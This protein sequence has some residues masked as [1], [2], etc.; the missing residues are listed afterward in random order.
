ML[1]WRRIRIAS[2]LVLALVTLTA[3]GAD[4]PATPPAAG[5]KALKYHTLLVKRPEPGFLFDR[6]Y[7][8][9]LDESTVDSLE[10]FLLERVQKSDTTGDRLL[11][12]FFYAKKG[13][14]VTALDQFRQALEHNPASAATWYHKALVEARTLDFDVAIADLKKAREQKPDEKLAVQIEKQLG[15]LLARNRQTAEA[16]KVWQALFA[17]NPADE[18]LNEDLIELHID[19]GLFKE[20]AQLEEQLVARTKDE[21][22]AVT[23]RLRL[24]DIYHRAGD[25]AKAIETYTNALDAV[26]GESWLEREILAQ[27]DQVYR[28]EDDVA[29]LKKLY[30]DLL[31]KYAKRISIRRRH[32]QMLVESADHDAA[33]AAYR[34]ILKLT[35]GER[36]T[37]EE[38]IS[39]LSRIGKQDEAVK[40]LQALCDQFPKDAELK[41]RLANTYHEAKQADACVAAV[42]KYLEA[43]DGSEYAYLRG[44]R[45]LER[46][47][48]KEAAAGL[49]EKMAAKFADSVA[50]QEAYAAFLY[51]S[52]NKKD[53]IAK[54]RNLA[55][56]ADL[57]QTLQVAR[58]LSART[59]HEAALELLKER[60]ADIK[61]EP[62]FLGQLVTT[63]LALK[64]HEEAIPWAVERVTLAETAPDLESAIDQ[65]A[66]TIEHADKLDDEIKKLEAVAKR[67]VSESCLLAE[68]LERGGESAKADAVLKQAAEGGNLLALSQQVRLHSQR[69]EWNMAA[70]ATRKILQLPGG[71]KSLHVRR[72]VELYQRDFQLEE[73]LKWIDEWK[74]LSPGSTLPWVTEARMLQTLGKMDDALK[75]LRTA[76][77]KF[78]EDEDLRVRLAEFYSE[79]EKPVDAM[80]IYWQLYEETEDL[81]G[82][83]RWA[84]SL[85]TIAQQQGTVQQL[86][87]DFEERVRSNRQSIGP[88]LALAEVYRTVDDYEGRR[89]ALTAAAKVKP[90]DMYLLQQVARAEEQ[91]GDWKAAVATLER[92]AA[93]DKTTRTREQIAHLYLNYGDADKGYSILFDLVGAPGADPRTLE[94]TADALCATQEWERAADFLARRLPEHPTDYRLR[95]LFAVALEESDRTE[96]AARQFS[97]LLSNQEE[98]PTKKPQAGQQAQMNW[99]FD[100]YRK[101]LP[102]EAFEWMQLMQHRYS[103]YTHRQ[104]RGY[105][106]RNV[107]SATGAGNRSTVHLP[108]NVDDVRPLA[109]SHLLTIAQ[110]LD[111]K[112][113]DQISKELESHGMKHSKALMHVD[114][115]RGDFTESLPEILEKHPK[116]EAVLAILV[117]NQ[118][119]MRNEALG[120]HCI[121]ALEVFRKSRPELAFMAAIQAGMGE[122][123][124][125]EQSGDEKTGDEEKT[126]GKKSEAANK[127]LD[128]ALTI[129]ATLEHPN[130][131]TVMSLTFALGGRSLGNS[132]ELD[133]GDAYREKLSKL[134]VKWYPEL[135]RMPQVGPWA[136]YAS[137]QSLAQNSDPT[138][139]VDFID[140]EVN[141]FQSG[142]KG[143]STQQQFMGSMHGRGEFLKALS[144]PPPFLADFPPQV[145]AAFVT[146]EH[147]NPYGFAAPEVT[148]VEEYAKKIRP[149]L[150]RVKSPVLRILL[151]RRA[152][153]NDVAE[154]SLKKLLAAKTPHLDS[155]LLAAA[156]AAEKE[157]HAE[158]VRLL[159]KAHYLPMKQDARK[160][161]DGAIVASVMAMLQEEKQSSKEAME[162]GQQASLRLRRSRLDSTQRTELVAAMEAF[163]L[164]KEAEKLDAQATAPS[165]GVTAI[166][167]TPSYSAAVQRT[168]ED[169]IRKLIAEG[170]RDVALKQLATEVTGNVRNIIGNPQN[171]RWQ[172][173]QFREVKQRVEAHG[174]VDDLLKA[175]SP[176]EAKN[177]Q[178]LTEYAVACQLFDRNKEARTALESAI[179][180]KPKDDAARTQLVL[181]LAREDRTTAGEQ[182]RQLSKAGKATFGNSLSEYVQDYEASYDERLGY[183]G[184]AV[185]LLKLTEE[186]DLQQSHWVENLLN[187]LARYMH[188]RRGSLPSMYIEPDPSDNEKQPGQKEIVAKRRKVHQEICEQLLRLPD[189][190]RTGFRH[191]LAAT[192]SAG[193][194][195]DD[196]ASR[197]EKILLDESSAKP[198]PAGGRH[199]VYYNSNDSEIRFRTPEEFVAHRAWKSGD[200]K[201]IDETLLPNLTG[202]KNRESRERLEQM[203]ILFRCAEGEFLA[204]AGEI[205]KN[206]RP[207][208]PGQTGNEG[209]AIVVDVWADRELKVDLQPLVLKQLKLEASSPNHYQAPGYVKRFIEGIAK[210]WDRPQQLAFLEELAKIYLGPAEKRNEF[211][212]KNYDRNNINWGTPNGRIYIYAQLMQYFYQRSDLVFTILEHLDQYEDHKP[213]EGFEYHMNAVVTKSRDKGVE[214]T[215]KLLESSPWLA[216]FDQFRPLVLSSRNNG[217]QP[218]LALLLGVSARKE[219]FRKNLK[220][221]LEKQQAAKPTFGGQLILASLSEE[222]DSPALLELIGGKR[223]AIEALPEKRQAELAA[224]VRDLSPP[225]AKDWKDL[226]DAAKSAVAW[227][228]GNRASESRSMLEKLAKAKRLEDI[229]VEHGQA[230]EF[231][232]NE[233][234]GLIRSDTPAAVK[235]FQRLC[236]LARDAQKRGQWHIHFSDGTTTDGYL[237]RHIGYS[238]GEQ[239]LKTYN[240]LV[241]VM[242]AK[243][244]PEFETSYS[245]SQILY[246]VTNTAVEKASRS[247]KGDKKAA[248]NKVRKLYELIGEQTDNRP[249]SMLIPTLYEHLQRESDVNLCK[250]QIE[251]AKTEMSGGTYPQLAADL[252]AVYGLIAAEKERAAAKTTPEKRLPLADYHAHF[253]QTINDESL[254]RSWRL[255]IAVFLLGRER[256]FLPIEVAVDVAKLYVTALAEKVPIMS[257]QHTRLTDAVYALRDED[258]AKEMVGQWQAK[259]AD[260]Y[261]RM[262]P[263][264]NRRNAAGESIY[265]LSS[266]SAILRALRLYL[267]VGDLERSNL[268]LRKYSTTIGHLPQTIATLVRAEQAEEAAKV[269]R[270]SWPRL[271]LDWSGEPRQTYDAEIE[272][273]LKAMLEKLDRDDERYVARILFASIPDPKNPSQDPGAPALRDERLA[274]LADEFSGIE[275]KDSTLKKICLILLGNNDASGPK[276]AQEVA[277][278]FDAKQIAVAF[279][280]DDQSRITLEGSLAKCHLVNQLR[281]G[282]CTAYAELL[283]SLSANRGDHDY[284]FDQQVSPLI[285]CALIALKNKSTKPWTL[286]QCTA[287]AKSLRGLLKDREYVN[288]RDY[289]GLHNVLVALACRTGQQDDWQTWVKSISEYN[290]NQLQNSGLSNDIWRLGLTLVGPAT[291][292]NLDARLSYFKNVSQLAMAK[293]WLTRSGTPYRLRGQNDRNYLTVLV[294]SGLLTP[295]ELKSHGPAAVEGIGPKGEPNFTKA[296]IAH[297]LRSNKEYEAAVQ[298]LRS[299]AKIDPSAKELS[300]SDVVYQTDLAGCLRNMK[301]FDEALAIIKALDGKEFDKTLKASCEK[302]K[303]EIEEAAKPATN[304]KAAE[305]PSPEKTSLEIRKLPRPEWFRFATIGATSV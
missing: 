31:K 234:L 60:I 204:K 236:E 150:D 61:R 191:W 224:L 82:K 178:K 188:G 189:Q 212:K 93:S 98:L 105:T 264:R 196:F 207:T 86:V 19:E 160:A 95:Y 33:I 277:A 201:L 125:A 2:T 114:P 265:E 52:G 147:R 295:E 285:D 173:Q 261:L 199:T 174:M 132:Q 45:L 176:G 113:Q 217:G 233:L 112:Q 303:R 301:Q 257:D 270:G 239:D 30:D 229:G 221:A 26:G 73:G 170:K 206:T 84:Q 22:L 64:K 151:A 245:V 102:D 266:S 56:G 171:Q 79:T 272:Q 104:Q 41:F 244:A 299:F 216:D 69:R 288:F 187:N 198:R 141:R 109:L 62:L 240:F 27:I 145:L 193:E 58:T 12:A 55:K 269:L 139:Y 273:R 18:E 35:P 15:K 251:W 39:V 287:V 134:L 106:V 181:L 163:G 260:R 250:S 70:D 223:E 153:L 85:A 117:M 208:N 89:R 205:T 17:A 3:W 128:E 168:P 90:D 232:R 5:Q 172:R 83:L 242:R 184:L 10:S 192:E 67:S 155:Y 165:T 123:R 43:S 283:T 296:A 94:S 271:Q 91:E 186:G 211:I 278:A 75:V 7:N 4:E 148:D 16:L 25:R 14:D 122:V 281:A 99:Y 140:D 66:M 194:P 49:Y 13:D 76:V 136:F 284:Q 115:N 293:K 182:L 267:A 275:F 241:D 156:W 68:L 268:L 11:L 24:G 262:S 197:A 111:E 110:S 77:L 137:S 29:G 230:D 298:L 247:V 258:V 195:T 119:S 36:S 54:W 74:R 101:L 255:H 157:D 253:R 214:A 254:P 57:A 286:E 292:E 305:T 1:D 149:L 28:R 42:D 200:W 179:A 21:Y 80:R 237:M 291:P 290:R 63:A 238:S 23:R 219:E 154:E 135:S 130:P 53:A 218:P 304:D 225:N 231:V 146:D 72:L 97:Q 175:I 235:A 222:K 92:A 276:V 180:I 6:F 81:T 226:S 100:I 263:P 116:D 185:E 302:M 107:L 279:A 34:E 143:Q 44:A 282:D 162:A 220:V 246:S 51:S 228:D 203:A 129:A 249:T 50:A 96:E 159:E 38:Y 190:A 124:S 248:E 164:K 177:P 158:A 133:V 121:T 46:L 126:G 48:K 167:S 161:V 210:T 108:S 297:W 88:L 169:R 252:H 259:W 40:E 227:L 71:L 120:P 118:M 243:N 294:K 87:Q 300:R 280:G 202:T 289:R 144:F 20:A 213:F 32:A 8:T 215:M 127:Y 256:N 183:A 65:A 103:A 209:M 131:M 274:K 142:G 37:R 78:Q 138:A 47:D 152:K 166:Y 59:E 9:W